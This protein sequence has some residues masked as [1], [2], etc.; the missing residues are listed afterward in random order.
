MIKGFNTLPKDIS[1]KV[2][3]DVHFGAD[4]LCPSQMHVLGVKI[5]RDSGL[6]VDMTRDLRNDFLKETEPLGLSLYKFKYD[7]Y[8]WFSF[9]HFS[10]YSIWKKWWIIDMWIGTSA[11]DQSVVSLCSV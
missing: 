7:S 4:I 9:I 6:L 11:Y 3:L 10:S 8:L 1:S 5:F 2:Y